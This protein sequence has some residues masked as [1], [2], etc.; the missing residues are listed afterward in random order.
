MD[1]RL[2]HFSWVKIARIIY[3]FKSGWIKVGLFDPFQNFV[4]SWAKNLIV[5]HSKGTFT[6][7]CRMCQEELSKQ[8]API[9]HWRE[10]LQKWHGIEKGRALDEVEVD[11]VVAL[12]MGWIGRQLVGVSYHTGITHVSNNKLESISKNVRICFKIRSILRFFICLFTWIYS[13]LHTNGGS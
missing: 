8:H 13:D 9:T 7:N 5:F 3:P 10:C 12:I 4:F 6:G 11:F 2:Y 1:K